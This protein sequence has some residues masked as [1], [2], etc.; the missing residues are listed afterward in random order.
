VVRRQKL[1]VEE[2]EEVEVRASAV[3]EVI[4]DKDV[5]VLAFPRQAAPIPPRLFAGAK[6]ED[7][8][9]ALVA[10]FPKE[11]EESDGGEEVEEEDDDNVG[12]RSSSPIIIALLLALPAKR[13]EAKINAARHEKMRLLDTLAVAIVALAAA[14]G[15]CCKAAAD[16]VRRCI[17]VFFSFA[18]L[19]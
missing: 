4:G 11:S 6:K 5:E 12:N 7:L 2:D 9:V 1:G 15:S 19:F 14:S 13:T 16:D 10:S 3:D 17:L 8:F 18:D